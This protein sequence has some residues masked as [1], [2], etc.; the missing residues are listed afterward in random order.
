MNQSP[1][2]NPMIPVKFIPYLVALAGVIAA[3][4]TIAPPDSLVF[5]IALGA[6]TVLSVLGIA[7][8]GLRKPAPVIDSEDEALKIV[9]EKQ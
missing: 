7:S 8:P 5:K 2:G 9:R 3:V 4:M 6:N 1:T